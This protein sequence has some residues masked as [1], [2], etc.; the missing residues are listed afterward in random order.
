M[1][2]HDWTRVETSTFHSFHTVWI[3]FLTAEL[4]K[5]L[6]SPYY[7]QAEQHLGRFVPDVLALHASDPLVV[8]QPPVPALGE[9][10]VGV[11][12]APPRA[13]RTQKISVSKRARPRTISIRHT[14]GHR[15]VAL[16]EIVSPGNKDT[17]AGL[18]EFLRK[19]EQALRAGVHVTL[20][21]PFPPGRYD[22]DGIHAAVAAR[23]EPG[24]YQLPADKP[25]TFVSYGTG[26]EL[27]AY[28][29]HLAPGDPLPA[30]ALFLTED[31]FVPLPLE[32]TYDEAV[33]GM[34]SFWRNVLEG[35]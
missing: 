27:T 23:F 8:P 11:L 9:G 13:S 19:V 25:L 29:E 31:W 5:V 10:N 3:G 30:Q 16:I 32:K 6:P 35:R 26:D 33:A 15:I 24:P 20:L 1:P 14:S 21:D 17:E 7:A 22:P 4:N 12:P 28:I 2:M 34:P 18:A